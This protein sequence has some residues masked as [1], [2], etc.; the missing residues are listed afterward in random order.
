LAQRRHFRFEPTEISRFEISHKLISGEDLGVNKGFKVMKKYCLLLIS[1]LFVVVGLSTTPSISQAQTY[2]AW[3]PNVAYSVG[4][5]VTYGGH[6]YK[7]IQAHTSLVG[8]EP[9]NVPALWQ[10][11]GVYTGGGVT[12]TS[13]PPTAIPSTSVPPTA[14]GSPVGPVGYM[15]CAAENGTCAFSGTASV[16][17]GARGAFNYIMATNSI[18]CNTATFGDPISGVAKSCYSSPA[19]YTFCANENSTC[20]FSGS[21]RVIYGANGTSTTAGGFHSTI[22]TNSAACNNATFGDPLSGVAK[23]CYYH[24]LVG[25]GPVGYILCAAENGTCAFSGTANVAYGANNAFKYAT[26]TNSIACNNATFGDPLSGVAKACYYGPAG[27]TLCAAENGTCAFSGT[28]SVAYGANGTST[29]PGGFN[30]QFA[31]NSIACNN[32]TFGDPIPGVGKSCYYLVGNYAPPTPT[33]VPPT[34]TPTNTSFWGDTSTIPAAHNV[35]TF[36]FLNRT[37]GKYP[38]SQ[39]YWSFNGQTHSIAEQ[40]YFDMPAN[41]SGRMYFYLGSPTSQYQDFIEF[42]IAPAQF[43]GNTTLV[44]GFGLKIAMRLHTSSGFDQAVGEDQTTFQEDRSVTFQKFMNEVPAEFKNLAVEQAPYH[45]PAPAHPGDT[46]FAAGGQYGTYFNSYA[47]SVGANATT[48]DIF[49]CSGA[50]LATNSALCSALNRHVAQLPQSQWATPSLFYQAAPANYYAQF[51]HNH[52]LGGLAYGFPYDDYGNQSTYLAQPNPQWM[53]I[54][55]G[56]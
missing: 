18:A 51:W 40:P 33:F 39:V 30:Y 54:A 17:F 48:Q 49:N 26:A 32:A 21:M 8:W 50:V 36:G 20:T 37:N 5:Q 6:L 15:L 44:D 24:S 23:G 35:M 9:P 41:S 25:L 4:Q 2:P 22:A 27:Y 43:N 7:C 31:T 1:L 10:D 47:A 16:A 38:D 19:G 46:Y 14:L 56:W 52:S 13:V 3:A 29:N 28:A 42:T 34:L 45:I 12:A 11:E 53:L 55:I